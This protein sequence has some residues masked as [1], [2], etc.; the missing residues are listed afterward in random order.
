MSE[1]TTHLSTVKEI[2]DTICS[3]LGKTLDTKNKSFVNYEHIHIDNNQRNN[4]HIRY[5][6]ILVSK[7]LNK[8]Q[9]NVGFLILGD[10]IEVNT[11]KIKKLITD[12]N[13]VEYNNHYYY[14]DSLK[15]HKSLEKYYTIQ[16]IEI[17]WNKW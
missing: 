4:S 1:L 13:L 17:E 8:I 6:P 10:Y 5:P 7:E 16:E 9:T 11:E 3:V 14:I 12:L 2:A 15:S